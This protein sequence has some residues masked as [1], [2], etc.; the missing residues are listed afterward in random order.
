ME[1]LCVCVLVAVVCVG[2]GLGPVGGVVLCLCRWQVQ[3]SVFLVHPVFNPVAPYGYLLCVFVYDKYL[4]SI[5]VC[6]CL[7]DLD[8]SRHHQ[9]HEEHG[10]LAKKNAK[11]FHHCWRG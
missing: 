11:T 4:K 5:L 1:L 9:F 10:R 3:V 2:R 8:L 7:M 6:V